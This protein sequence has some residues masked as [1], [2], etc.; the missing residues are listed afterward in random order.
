MSHRRPLQASLGVR[1]G[2]GSA[3][4]D[5]PVSHLCIKPPS[6]SSSPSSAP[7]CLCWAAGSLVR[8]LPGLTSVGTHHPEPSRVQAVF[9]LYRLSAT[10]RLPQCHLETWTLN[11][12]YGV[13]GILPGEWH[14]QRSRACCGPRGR[15]EPDST[16]LLTTQHNTTQHKCPLSLAR[17]RSFFVSSLF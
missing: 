1:H 8:P 14:G 6:S 16:A 4:E 13:S 11:V 9:A 5:G 10:H 2:A 15:K 7:R 12:T 17:A 3:V